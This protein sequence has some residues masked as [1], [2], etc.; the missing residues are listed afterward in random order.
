MALNGKLTVPLPEPAPVA[1]VLLKV[2]TLK[3][4]QASNLATGFFDDD[5]L[6]ETTH[7]IPFGPPPGGM[8]LSHPVHPMKDEPVLGE[9]TNV[10]EVPCGSETVLPLQ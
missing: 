8:V 1:A 3:L 2:Y 6:A 9:A 5:L 10:T 4:G 7:L